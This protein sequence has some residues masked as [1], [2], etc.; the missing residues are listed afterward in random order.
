MLN[1]QI[2]NI[3]YEQQ[4]LRITLEIRF[5]LLGFS[6]DTLYKYTRSSPL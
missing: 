3:A 5:T 6:M 1:K 4:G 2:D